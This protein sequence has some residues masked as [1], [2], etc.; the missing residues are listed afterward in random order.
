MPNSSETPRAVGYY[1][2]LRYVPD[3]IRGESVNIGL[4][5]VD[6]E[7]RW[8]RFDARTPKGAIRTVG[9][10][11]D[12]VEV[13]RWVADLKRQFHVLGDEP[14]FPAEGR[15][16]PNLLATWASRFGGMLR[17]SEPTVAVGGQMD[18]LWNQLYGRLVK[19][20]REARTTVAVRTQAPTASDERREVLSAL[21]AEVR[22]WPNYDQRL[23]RLNHIFRGDAAEH[24]VDV[25][26]MNGQIRGVANV[27]PIAHGDNTDI[28]RARSLLEDAA[29]DLA[30]EV[31]KLALIE[32]PSADRA[33]LVDEVLA[34]FRNMPEA[35]A[36]TV[37]L[38]REF[39]DL[40]TR[41]A[42]TLFG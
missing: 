19:R 14:L 4:F 8:A 15:L 32:E 25:A 36:I 37:V 28:I 24:I 10:D 33:E 30:P 2:V 9:S 11:R 41:F 38:R 21:E 7:G 31:S 29:L 34:V 23:F 20:P 22:D 42:G 6:R 5:L 40:E 18:A 16:D 39:P 17:V 12:V 35:H 1:S 27:I 3:P 26:F 13:E